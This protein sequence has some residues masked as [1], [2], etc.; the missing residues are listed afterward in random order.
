MTE[1]TANTALKTSM[2]S[3]SPPALIVGSTFFF[4]YGNVGVVAV[5]ECLLDL[6]LEPLLW[7]CIIFMW[8]CLVTC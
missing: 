4:F 3:L 2:I 5:V 6:F 1:N 8:L 7:F